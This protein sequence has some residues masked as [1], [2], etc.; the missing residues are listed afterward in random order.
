MN[1]KDLEQALIKANDEAF[2]L[3]QEIT[4]YKLTHT[5][6]YTKN[7]HLFRV[8]D[9]IH[10]EKLENLRYT[11]EEDMASTRDAF[12]QL[13]TNKDVLKI[14]RDKEGITVTDENN[15][16]LNVFIN[17]LVVV[18][19]LVEDTKMWH[20]GY[21]T[22]IKDNSEKI[23]VEHLERVGQGNDIWRFPKKDDICEV[24]IPQIKGISLE[25][26]WDYTNSRTHKLI[27]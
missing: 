2:C 24:D 20:L 26:E 4:Y 21:I 11:E 14:L 6:E 19:W 27:L 12:G 7:R 23:I 16:N 3:I 17:A 8:R 18:I 13:P 25:S 10:E 5:T 1:S 22:E 9:I 15:D